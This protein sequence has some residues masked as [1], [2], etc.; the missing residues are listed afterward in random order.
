LAAFSAAAARGITGN[1][2]DPFMQGPRFLCECAFQR[3]HYCLSHR[4]T[5]AGSQ[6]SCQPGGAVVANVQR[7]RFSQIQACLHSYHP[8]YIHKLLC[9]F[10]PTRRK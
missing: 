1:D 6:L 4:D 10:N 3:R 9:Q 5:F 7:H 2:S 8:V